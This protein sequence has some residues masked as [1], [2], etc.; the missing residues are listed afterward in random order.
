MSAKMKRREFV[1][2]LGAAA[3]R[4]FRNPTT[5]IAERPHLVESFRRGLSEAG[6]VAGQN[7]RLGST[8]RPR[9][10]RSPTR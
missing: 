2:L 4:P 9:C 6:Y 7:V 1:T 3:E 8:C 10:S 5:G